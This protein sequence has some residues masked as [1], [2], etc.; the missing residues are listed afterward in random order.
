MAKRRTTRAIRRA[1]KRAEK[2]AGINKPSGKSKYARTQLGQYQPKVD[3]H[4]RPS[5]FVRSGLAAMLEHDAAKAGA[6]RVE[7]A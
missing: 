5:W 7:A 2:E 6:R 1:Q 3:P 4:R